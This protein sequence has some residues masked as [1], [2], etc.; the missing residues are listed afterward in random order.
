MSCRKLVELDPPHT[1]NVIAQAVFDC[2]TEWKLEDKVMTITLDNASNNN[3][4]IK[5]LK[6][7]FIARRNSQFD[8]VYFHVRC[9]SH[10]VNLVV[11]DGLQLDL[12]NC[13]SRLS[14]RLGFKKLD[15][16]HAR[17]EPIPSLTLG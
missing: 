7:K 14:F 3:T 4:A 8:P 5:S 15:R 16:K 12:F 2:L 9:S 6:T 10:I 13:R 17:S 11:N 1:A